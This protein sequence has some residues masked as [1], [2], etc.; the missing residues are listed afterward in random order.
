V[1]STQNRTPS[2][3]GGSHE[4]CRTVGAAVVNQ[5]VFYFVLRVEALLEPEQFGF[6]DIQRGFLIAHRDDD[7]E[8]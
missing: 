8:Q 6:E 4:L 5:A 2:G 3:S 7:R 1:L